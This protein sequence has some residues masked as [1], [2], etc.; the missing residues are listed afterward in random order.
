M[1]SVEVKTKQL[2]TWKLITRLH[3]YYMFTTFKLCLK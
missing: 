1:V 3:F 2:Q